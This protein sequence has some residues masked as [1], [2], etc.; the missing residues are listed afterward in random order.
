MKEQVEEFVID[1]T[2]Q[3]EWGG[4]IAVAFFLAG[5]GS[6]AFF[7]AMLLEQ[8][9]GLASRGIATLGLLIVALGAGGTFVLDL[10]RSFRFWRALSNPVSSW[11]SR[12]VT[13]IVTFV[14]FGI[15]AVSGR[16]IQT[17]PW[18]DNAGAGVFQIIAMVA[19]FGVM[20]YSGFVLVNNPGIAFWNNA[21]LPVL[22]VL[23][24]FMGGLAIIFITL[25]AQPN[26]KASLLKILETI[27]IWLIV[28]AIILLGIY[29]LAMSTSTEGAR[30][31]V[32]GLLRGRY[33]LYF[34]GGGIG[35]G[36]L[37][38]LAVALY[39]LVN[40]V[41]VYS[42]SIA[43]GI[44]GVLELLGGFLIRYCFLRAAMYSPLL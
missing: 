1:F 33:S 26:A 9:A 18:S 34:L 44:A 15:L 7:L 25:P 14:V 35:I 36:L 28:F 43:L 19:A 17:L 10:G 24:S 29:L 12:G 11:I 38:P 27:E 30:L 5:V 42:A 32:R 37:V 6:G 31:T 23:Y 3:K 22:F 8:V 16:W 40:G 21:L 2:S 41:D 39:V 13:F 4:L 20:V